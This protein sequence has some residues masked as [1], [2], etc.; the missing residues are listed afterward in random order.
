MH[1][2]DKIG[3]EEYIGLVAAVS[4]LLSRNLDARETFILA[5]FLDAVSDQLITL[6]AFKEWAGK[7]RPPGPPTPPIQPAK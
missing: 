6:A 1:C 7:S 5:E 2:P 3:G 4:M